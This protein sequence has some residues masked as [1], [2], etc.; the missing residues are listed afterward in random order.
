MREASLR[1][2]LLEKAIE[3]VDPDGRWIALAD[4]DA[5]TREARREIERTSGAKALSAPTGLE[6]ALV[7]RARRL[8][9]PLLEQ[10]PT[11]R[12]LAAP[13]GV[14]WWVGAAVIG[15]AIA[16]GLGL[17]ALDGSRRIDILALPILGVVGWN[18]LVC[19]WFAVTRLRRAIAQ[20]TS[21]R[22]GGTWFGTMAGR[23]LARLLAGRE[24][25]TPPFDEAA[26]RFASGLGEAS[27]P[28]VVR[29]LRRLLHLAAA[30]VALGL[31]AGFYL[32][33]IVF[34]F[35]A[36][37]ESTF[38][39]TSQV[40]ALLQVLYG[41][42][43]DWAGIAL[44]QS[45]EAVAALRWTQDGG[46]GDA[47]PWIHLI[48]LSLALYVMLPRLALA[49]FE[50]VAARRLRRTVELPP[51]LVAFG[52]SL[53]G[54]GAGLTAGAPSSVVN[55]SLI[56]HTNAGKTTLART[57]LRRDVG[58]VRDAPH[59]TTSATAYE[60]I[61]TSQ[62]DVLQLWDTP[63][64]N[65]TERLA[66]RLR[67][68]EN[69]VGWL[70]AQVWDRVTDRDFFLS[71]RAVRNVREHTDL[72]LYVVDAS[73]EPGA[74]GYLESEMSILGWI[75]KPV[76]VLLNQLGSPRNPDSELARIREWRAELA[77]FACIRDVLEF[78]AFA[79]CWVQEHTLLE[80]IGVLLPAAVQPAFDRVA[81]RWRE[82]NAEVFDRSMQ[83]L[84]RQLAATAT[85]VATI[86]GRSL[87][88]T[89]RAWFG[90][91]ERGDPA[92]DRA[93]GELA[94]RL[95]GEVRQATDQLIGLHGLSG[96]AATEVLARMGRELTISKA[97]D[98]G[99]VS[100]L[101]GA[102]T[103]A[104]GGL[105]ADLA[106]GGLTFGAGALIGGLLGVAG[107]RTAARAYNLARGVDRSSVR[108]SA[109]FLTG[110]VV[111]AVM[112]YLAVAH[113]GRGRGA[114][115]E[116]EFPWHWRTTVEAAVQSRKPEL[117][118]LWA[119]A[120][121]GTASGDLERRLAPL[122]RAITGEVLQGLYPAAD[123]PQ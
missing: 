119:D 20:G 118:L 30:A 123:R 40:L 117:S 110:R 49:A 31:L 99:R 50:T 14:P 38:L 63:G 93:A 104:L 36:G 41:P 19:L 115:A 94:T 78:D 122:V 17:S 62:G 121:G 59:V 114:F 68:S 33:G 106:A 72:V 107:A 22:P 25:W 52:E 18:L 60:L 85:D 98:V 56:S 75:G 53:Y 84:A 65:G 45:I 89:A 13:L 90:G 116:D 42:V 43:A 73:D 74:A 91:E 55:L 37:W 21:A 27:G 48:A 67:Q 28:L 7:E 86:G 24:T 61:A 95:D 66:A 5:A 80:K 120:A 9:D 108:W 10:H 44:P 97:A 34:R 46:G 32:R 35:E 113:F 87:G 51:Q 70:L 71:Q 58:E 57:L 1:T 96:Q 81:L 16:S 4:R 102:V 69:P 82:R 83:V 8:L 112:R 54:P 2:V 47:A 100:V 88:E 111:A 3:D 29:N 105:A 103:G 101:G 79:R 12:P 26:A 77:G 92:A 39:G 15:A 11:L 109:D 64:F 6:A 76:L 23:R